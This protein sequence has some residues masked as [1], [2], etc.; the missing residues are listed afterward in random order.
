MQQV[1]VGFLGFGE[2][3]FHFARGLRQNGVDAVAVYSRSAAQAQPGD[4]VLARA[5]EAGVSIAPSPKALC[6][7]SDVIISVV[8]GAAA[9]TAVRSVRAALRSDQLYVD[10]TTA[11]VETMEKGAALIEGRAGYVDVAIMGPVP[12]GGIGTPL[13][14]SGPAAQRFHDLLAPF[15]MNVTVLDGKPGAATAMKLI[16]SV[17]MKGIA[18]VLIE[19]LDAAH[20]HGIL[21]A[22]AED[23]AQSMDERPFM[24]TIERHVIGTAMHAG[25]RVHEMTEVLALLKHL[26]ASDHMSRAARA[27]LK[28]IAA[29][30]LKAHFGGVEPKVIRPVIEAMVEKNSTSGAAG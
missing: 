2:A 27:K 13:T 7:Q 10:A 11:A 15:G 12:L 26:G 5:A 4:A 20:R 9:L 22:V 18:N 28:H 21:E 23:I 29:M 16:R 14:A 6:Q 8:P 1:R 3:G 17:S 19:A 24:Q 30:E 25:R